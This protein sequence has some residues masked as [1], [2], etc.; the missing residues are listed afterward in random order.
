[1]FTITPKT[2]A[3]ATLD[4]NGVRGNSS[5][6]QVRTSRIVSTLARRAY[7][8]PVNDA[9]LLPLMTFVDQGVREGGFER[10]IEL[11]L[12]AI[13]VSPKFVFLTNGLEQNVLVEGRRTTAIASRAAVCSL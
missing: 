7:R 10:G 4:R 12:R 6:S 2:S 5:R 8:R 9:D 3:A 11:A 1:M 13:L